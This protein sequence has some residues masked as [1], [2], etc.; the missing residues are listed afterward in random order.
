MEF[1]GTVLASTAATTTLVGLILWLFKQLIQNRLKASIEHEFN[2]KLAE[3]HSKLRNSEESFKAELRVNETQ[4]QSLQSTALSAMAG[5]QMGVDK[6]RLEAIDQLW[7]AVHDLSRARSIAATTSIIK[8]DA[9]SKEIEGNPKLQEFFKMFGDVDLREVMR[10]D[11]W[12][13]R[14]FVS[15]LAWAYFSAFRAVVSFAAARL[16]LLQH[17]VGAEKFT[18]YVKVSDMVKAALPHQVA[19]I[20]KFGAAALP[21]LLDELEACLLDEFSLMLSGQEADQEGVKRAAAIAAA[22]KVVEQQNRDK[23]ADAEA[24]NEA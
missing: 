24:K 6:R 8:F 4:I 2:A 1:I 23:F 14:P 10:E 3:L 5:R 15:K 16:Y 12:K 17:G 11:G 19:Y 13:A 22:V 20:D 9:V 18:D 21:L 7:S